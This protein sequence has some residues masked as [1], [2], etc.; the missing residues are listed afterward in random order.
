MP[1]VQCSEEERSGARAEV[2]DPSRSGCS[3]EMLDRGRDQDF[4]IRPRDEYS[5]PHVKLDIPE[6]PSSGDIG[7]RLAFRAAR[8]HFPEA[9]GHQTIG[10][11]EKQPVAIDVKRLGHQQLGIEARRVALLGQLARGIVQ[12]AGDRLQCSNSLHSGEGKSSILQACKPLGFVLG[13]ECVYNLG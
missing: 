12:R 5:G 7:D 2:E 9:L 11:R 6:G 1:D 10:R 3:V 13:D 4:R 8:D